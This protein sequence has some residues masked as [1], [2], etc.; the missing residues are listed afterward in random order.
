M[1]TLV[2]AVGDGW[3]LEING[4]LP[5]LPADITLSEDTSVLTTPGISV[6]TWDRATG[7]MREYDSP[8][9]IEPLFF[10]SV[11][12][13]LYLTA[14]G[15]G[16]ELGGNA[17]VRLRHTI[18][19]GT[20]ITRHYD[21]EFHNLVGKT[22]FTIT[23]HSSDASIG[24][25][26]FPRKLNYRTDYVRMRDDISSV[27]RQLVMALHRSTFGDAA[28]VS[29]NRPTLNEWMSLLEKYFDTFYASTR[30]IL[31]D[32]K[33]RL[34]AIDTMRP[35]DRARRV[36]RM[37]FAQAC[38]A[39]PSE[40]R[41][42]SGLG[43]S[44]PARIQ[45]S[46]FHL[47]LDTAENRYL[48]HLLLQTQ[49][50]LRQMMRL[51]PG[52]EEDSDLN[53]EERFLQSFKPACSR[54]LKR[55]NELLGDRVFLDIAPSPV[56]PAGLRLH[57]NPHYASVGKVGRLLNSG[58]S[59][60]GGP[61]RVG[62]RQVS[63]LYEYWCFLKLIEL[64]ARRFELKGSSIARM[65][66][67]RSSVFLTKGKES[68]VTFVDPRSQRPFTLTYNRLFGSLPTLN[69]QPDNVI[70]L[71]SGGDLYIFDAKY[72]VDADDD[73]IQRHGSPGPVADDL[74]VMHR[75]RD[76]IVVRYPAD[77]SNYKS[78]VKGAVVLF[79]YGDEKAYE[80]NR[81]FR[82]IEAVQIGGLPFL[83]SATTL[84]TDQLKTIIDRYLERVEA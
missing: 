62:V 47:T 40:H 34:V 39:T 33:A 19:V 82:S 20:S 38:R 75:Y 77:A 45:E 14:Q 53:A 80:R 37:A 59:L 31:A 32:P 22:E 8:S 26:V 23:G 25:E 60:S 30:R 9:S 76:A 43:I 58:L 61:L 21:L 52:I 73:Y 44:L 1:P 13:H 69:Q 49:R 2:T 72:R 29:S 11:K 10:E 28:A 36:T 66:H 54:M 84:V 18:R 3:S 35:T 55:I 16:A 27:C 42:A 67:T 71:G 24:F 12:Y 41:F 83:P 17:P 65:G 79:P 4:D 48:K 46:R 56:P 50:R 74:N 68:T 5:S 63:L 7:A 78:M 51:A 81:F 64:M 57:L 6:A 70:E 15:E